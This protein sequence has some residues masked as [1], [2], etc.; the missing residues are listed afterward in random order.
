MTVYNRAGNSS[1]LS[2]TGRQVNIMKRRGLYGWVMRKSGFPAFGGRAITGGNKVTEDELKFLQ[3]K[4]CKVALYFDELT[5][6]SVSSMNG[7]DDALRAIEGAK[8]LGV[9]ADNGIAIFAVIGKDW[10]VNHNWMIS[11]AS[12]IRNQRIHPRFWQ[13]YFV[14]ILN[15]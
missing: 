3:E 13:Q 6:M 12:M 2:V 11:F 14:T 15:D 9:P 5:E 1:I 8:A 7:A 10:S 4:K